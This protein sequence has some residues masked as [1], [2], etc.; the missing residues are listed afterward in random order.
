MY[1]GDR[2]HLSRATNAGYHY[3]IGVLMDTTTP[4]T[5][6][7]KITRTDGYL[8]FKL[9]RYKLGNDPARTIEV[10][11]GLNIKCADYPGLEITIGPNTDTG[12]PVV[13]V[14]TSGMGEKFHDADGQP[15]IAVMINDGELYDK[16]PKRYAVTQSTTYMVIAS[17]AE[18]ASLLVSNII[19]TLP[20]GVES[21]NIEMHTETT[22]KHFTAVPHLTDREG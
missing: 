17:D 12:L 14:D 18:N 21:V 6:D 8:G 5:A 13:I 15:F 19:E 7:I 22:P 4:A 10:P 9:E 11:Y 3:I 1:D 2:Q 20:F 16:K